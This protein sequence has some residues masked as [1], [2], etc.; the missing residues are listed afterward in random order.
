MFCKI[1]LVVYLENKVKEKKLQELLNILRLVLIWSRSFK[2]NSLYNLK[3][4][5]KVSIICKYYKLV[6]KIFKQ[7]KNDF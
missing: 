4:Y 5:K 7:R 6:S 3:W 2:F 1:T